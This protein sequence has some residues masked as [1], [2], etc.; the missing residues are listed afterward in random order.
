[1]Q[2]GTKV[3]GKRQA[4]HASAAI[5][6][7]TKPG[8]VYE[9]T[10]YTEGIPDENTAIT[11][12]LALESQVADLKVL[13]VETNPDN[14]ITLQFMD[15]GPG[16][17]ALGAL[18]TALPG[19]LFV[20]GLIIVG[21]LAYQIYFSASS[22]LLPALV[23]IGGGLAL[24]YLTSSAEKPGFLA[25]TGSLR[26]ES[27][28]ETE[29]KTEKKEKRQQDEAE[30][31]L[32]QSKS[33]LSKINSEITSNAA[34]IEKKNL[35]LEDC[36]SQ[37]KAVG[38]SVE[39]AKKSKDATLLANSKNRFESKLKQCNDLEKEKISL[40]KIGADLLQ[41]YSIEKEEFNVRRQNVDSRAAIEAALKVKKE[42]AKLTHLLLSAQRKRQIIAESEAESGAT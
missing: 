2:F 30:K 17:I 32:E 13:Y 37:E 28:S 21:I 18:F 38:K 41:Q 1:M 39:A 36:Y 3:T 23:V 22:W 4:L 31:R 10:I 11:Q 12:V 29:K 25:V 19:F 34:E 27:K 7:E 14:T 26:H 40:T 24:I 6:V 5:S 16:A 15:A 20:A 33:N 8:E 35:A 9:L 42:E